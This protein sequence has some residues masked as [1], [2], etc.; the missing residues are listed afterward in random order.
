[1]AVELLQ[2]C[3]YPF[4]CLCENIVLCL[5]YSYKN[6]LVNWNVIEW[7]AFLL[8]PLV[9]RISYHSCLHES[10]DISS[11]WLDTSKPYPCIFWWNLCYCAKDNSTAFIQGFISFA[12]LCEKE[13]KLL[14]PEKCGW[15][16]KCV[17]FKHNL[18]IEILNIQVNITLE[19]MPE[20]FIGDKSTLVQVMAWCR[21]AASHCLNQWW[22]SLMSPYGV[23]RPQWVKHKI[24]WN[25]SIFCWRHY[26]ILIWHI[27]TSFDKTS[28]YL[29]MVF[30]SLY[31]GS[32]V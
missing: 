17:K 14:F 12:A 23:T 6:N 31:P 9:A 19:W 10:H 25:H 1:M 15:D 28:P 2:S 27:L 8:H 5:R 20:D 30:G 32:F 26:Q 4:M 11:E 21:Q 29:C 16:F 22:P 24:L 3:I 18:K 7:M 13:L